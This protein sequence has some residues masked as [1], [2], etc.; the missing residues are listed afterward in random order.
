MKTSKKKIPTHVAIIMDG[1][2]RW[3][4]KRG[5]PRIAGHKEGIDSVRCV[6]E[7][8]M[9]LGIKYLTLYAFSSE[10]WA[11]PKKEVQALMA[12]LKVYLDEKTDEFIEKGIRLRA[13][14]ELQRL[15]AEVRES[16]KKSIEATRGCS[17]LNLIL[18]LSYGGRLE[19][20]QAVKE[21]AREV[22]AGRLSA[23]KIN[24]KTISGHLYTSDVPDPDLL[25]RTSNE[26]RISNFLLWQLSYSEFYFSKK[27]WP[28]I[29][30]KD[31][32][33]IIENYKK[34]DRRF[35]KV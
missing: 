1:N 24:E 3:A 23:S 11:R 18:A 5:L 8:A 15:P 6:I 22:K 34:R 7:A 32:Y 30:K 14:G 26:L 17:K 10:N 19:I 21:I 27:Y 12:Y 9:E 20:I 25:I 13:I 2:G 4:K 35:G 28:D 16:L 31:F 29:K 33:R